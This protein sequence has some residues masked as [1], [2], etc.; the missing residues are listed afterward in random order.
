[1]NRKIVGIL[2]ALVLAVV[3]TVALVSYVQSAKDEAVAGEALV[4]AYVLSSGVTKGASLDTVRESVDLTEV[5]AKVR[6][7][8]AVTDLDALDD[9]LVAGVNLA[10]GELLLRSRLVGADQLSRAQVPD[11]LQEMTL[12]LSPER[13]VGGTLRAGDTVGIVLSFEPFDISGGGKTPNMTHLTF[14]KV[15]VTSVQYAQ[16]EEAPPSDDEEGDGDEGDEESVDR[17]PTNELL[18]TLAL[19]SPQVE[20][21]T[22]G[23]EFGHVWLT[24]EP[25]DATEDGTRIVTLDKVYGT[26]GIPGAVQP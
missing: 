22:F 18:V 26:L 16:N 7:D 14:H 11:G 21:V 2:V 12:S 4:D 3:G 8:D 23:A 19:S 15:L 10:E 24:A 5:P 17:A 20:Q 25:D 6:P 13:T 1:M 9:D